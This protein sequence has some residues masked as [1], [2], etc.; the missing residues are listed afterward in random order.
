[1]S[2]MIHFHAKPPFEGPWSAF[3]ATLVMMTSEFNYNESFDKKLSELSEPVFMPRIIF[4][5]FLIL[6]SIVLMNLIVGVAVNDVNN[7]EIIGSIKRLEKQVEFISSLEDIVCN[8][9]LESIL[10]KRLYSKFKNNIKLESVIVLR[11][12]KAM[13][14]NRNRFPTRL[15]EATFERV[16]LQKKQSDEYQGS[17]VFQMKLDEMSSTIKGIADKQCNA[18]DTSST[19]NQ[20][21]NELHDLRSDMDKIKQYIEITKRRSL[22]SNKSTPLLAVPKQQ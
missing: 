6:V 9:F 21:F 13:C 3:V 12:R 11:P 10:P 18:N 19:L 7:L 1:M 16:Q 15:R 4:I 5:T 2:F 8:K 14:Y 22:C 17:M 20:I